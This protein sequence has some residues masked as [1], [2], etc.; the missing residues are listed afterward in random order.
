MREKIV[1]WKELSQLEKYCFQ[2]VES[3]VSYDG[4]L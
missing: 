3:D 2:T 4:V 1:F